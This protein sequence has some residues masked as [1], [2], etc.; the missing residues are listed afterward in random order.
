MLKLVE[1]DDCHISG[2][3]RNIEVHDC[4]QHLR[5][6]RG[7]YDDGDIGTQT[8]SRDLQTLHKILT[9]HEL[10]IE[11]Y[12]DKVNT[13]SDAV[14]QIDLIGFLRM[15]VL[16]RDIVVEF[17]YLNVAPDVVGCVELCKSLVDEIPC[18]RVDG[19]CVASFIAVSDGCIAGNQPLTV[20]RL[21]MA[22]RFLTA[23]GDVSIV[24][25]I[26]AILECSEPADTAQELFLVTEVRTVKIRQRTVGICYPAVFGHPAAVAVK[27]KTE[28]FP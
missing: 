14:D 8:V 18:F 21:E 12:H 10:G 17:I 9:L 6:D 28:P 5:L 13:S 16:Q 3:A 15:N 20:E 1:L 26:R 7:R 24:D 2:I 25:V 27:G 19:D 4:A 23:K 11:T 22:P